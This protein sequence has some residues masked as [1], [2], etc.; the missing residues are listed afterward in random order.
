MCVLTSI[1]PK[2]CKLIADGTKTIEIR[3]TMPRQVEVP[4]KCYM[5]CTS[6]DHLWKASDAV[7]LDSCYNRLIDDMPTLLSNKVIGEFICDKIYHYS[8]CNVEGVDISDEDITKYSCLSKDEIGAYEM[9][10]EPKENCIYRIGVYG[11][12]I[13]NVAIYDSPKDLLDFGLKR[14]PQSWC[15]V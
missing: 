4:V 15:Y 11:W 3:K 13:S 9:S 6:G 1:R 10:S 8:T 2:W 12:H 5:Y 14:P 7:F